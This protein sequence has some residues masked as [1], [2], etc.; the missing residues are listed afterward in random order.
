MSKHAPH[1]RL[2]KLAIILTG[3]I[4]A[5]LCGLGVSLYHKNA[6]RWTP[7]I[8]PENETVTSL[9]ALNR[10]LAPYV[11]TQS[12]ALY[13]C[14]GA[15]WLDG[16]KQI[17][18]AELPISEVHPK[19][20]SCDPPFPETPPAPGPIVDAIEVGQCAEARTYGKV[21]LLADNTLWRWQRTFSWVQ[22]FTIASGAVGGLLLGLMLGTL[23]VDMWRYL[24]TPS[25]SSRI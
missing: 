18:E 17:T 3:L 4:C 13:F 1:S 19:W 6:A 21:I 5:L 14:S 23:G 20:L 15:Q 8:G 24:R 25:P 12:G 11:K 9:V 10:V 16:C 7:L 2:Q 22:P